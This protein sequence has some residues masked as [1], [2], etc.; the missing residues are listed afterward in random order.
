MSGDVSIGA[1]GP[2]V[3]CIL[4]PGSCMGAAGWL[5]LA[6]W[7]VRSCFWPSCGLYLEDWK[8]RFLQAVADRTRL[9]GWLAL[10]AWGVRDLFAPAVGFI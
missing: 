6:G 5:A 1:A 2:N 3:D 8:A 9:A 4:E 7:D 10:F